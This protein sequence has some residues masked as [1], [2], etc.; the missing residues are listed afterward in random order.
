MSEA[1]VSTQRPEASQEARLPPPDVDPSGA[2]RDQGSPPEGSRPPVR[3]IWRIERRDTFLALRSGRRGRSGPLVVSWV[4]GDPAQPPRVAFAV[5]R[6]VGNAVTRNRVRRQLRTLLRDVVPVLEPGAWLVAVAPSATVLSYDEL[7]T[8]LTAAVTRALASPGRA[9]S[10]TA[11][12]AP[13]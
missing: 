3:L 7:A 8:T 11:G 6:R 1:Y 5:G 9:P 13:R 2:R 12:R 4:P 10:P